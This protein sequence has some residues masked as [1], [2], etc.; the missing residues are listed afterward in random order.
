MPFLVPQSSTVLATA[1][2]L[3]A[4]IGALLFF[5]WDRLPRRWAAVGA[6]LWVSLEVGVFAVMINSFAA[7]DWLD[8]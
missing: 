4:L 7:M 8:Y 5:A 3:I 1:F 2:Y 6:W